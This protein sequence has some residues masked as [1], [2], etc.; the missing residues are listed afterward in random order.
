M[1]VLVLVLLLVLASASSASIASKC[2]SPLFAK[3]FVI[4]PLFVGFSDSTK[5][6][7]CIF[8][9]VTLA[10]ASSHYVKSHQYRNIVAGLLSVRV[11]T[12][13]NY[14]GYLL[15]LNFYRDL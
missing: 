14:K 11:C 15:T 3:K 12:V 9:K 13:Q 8:T 6:N 1:L 7:P 4:R 5:I 2:S 10:A